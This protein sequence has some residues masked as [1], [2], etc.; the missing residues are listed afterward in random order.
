[1]GLIHYR[2]HARRRRRPSSSISPPS[3]RACPHQAVQHRLVAGAEGARPRSAAD[4]ARPRRRG[5]GIEG[6]STE[7]RLYD[8]LALQRPI[9][10]LFM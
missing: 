1:M 7:A 5:D 2:P 10:R 9:F 3:L 6:A 8:R 4:A